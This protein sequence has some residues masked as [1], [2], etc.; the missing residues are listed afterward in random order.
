[1]LLCFIFGASATAAATI[2]NLPREAS[3]NNYFLFLPQER[4]I[5]SS[6][7]TTTRALSL[8]SII[9]IRHFLKPPQE[10]GKRQ[11]NQ[12]QIILSS[13]ARAKQQQQQQPNL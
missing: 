12:V 11:Q 4:S 10:N 5:S 8:T 9:K 2:Q 6:P 3:R 13:L 7:T 1:V